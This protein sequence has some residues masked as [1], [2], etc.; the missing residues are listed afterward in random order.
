M[1]SN[2]MSYFIF[3]EKLAGM[4]KQ[5]KSQNVCR[6]LFEGSGRSSMWLSALELHVSSPL[7]T[8]TIVLVSVPLERR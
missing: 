4:S 2:K 6:G 7:G 3:F 5:K 1:N 8:T